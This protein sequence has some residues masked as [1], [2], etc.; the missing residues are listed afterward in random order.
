MLGY[1]ACLTDYFS[2]PQAKT[3]EDL[4]NVACI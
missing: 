2:P 1:I 3:E 4:Q